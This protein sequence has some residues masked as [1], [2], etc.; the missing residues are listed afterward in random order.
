MIS[1]TVPLNTSVY[2]FRTGKLNS[3][4]VT[5]PRK[6][7]SFW[8]DLNVFDIERQSSAYLPGGKRFYNFELEVGGCSG[9]TL[10]LTQTLPP[11][12]KE[13]KRKERVEVRFLYDASHKLALK[14]S[15][16]KS[17]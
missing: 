3:C 16:H 15:T 12:K 4:I 14:V 11:G 9:S 6:L 5:L 10:T 2:S 8:V 1:I 7:F 13:K 17:F